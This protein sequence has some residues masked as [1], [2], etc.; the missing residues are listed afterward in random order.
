[1]EMCYGVPYPHYPNFLACEKPLDVESLVKSRTLIIYPRLL[2]YDWS[3]NINYSIPTQPPCIFNLYHLLHFIWDMC[4]HVGGIVI[5][6]PH[7]MI[8]MGQT[9]L[10]TM[11][12]YMKGQ[13]DGCHQGLAFGTGGI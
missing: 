5:M 7:L 9:S 4:I 13:R 8:P 6:R 1:M 10:T 2:T 3:N 12:L 11:G